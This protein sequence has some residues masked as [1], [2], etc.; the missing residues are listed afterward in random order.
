[1]EAISVEGEGDS[2]VVTEE[3]QAGYTVNNS[4]IRVAMV[5]V[6]RQ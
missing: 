2:E 6:K 5:K 4:V 3:L 1:M